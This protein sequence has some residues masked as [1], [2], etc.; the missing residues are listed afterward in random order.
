[1]LKRL[2][3]FIVPALALGAATAHAAPTISPA[4]RAA[5]R[6]DAKAQNN[7]SAYKNPRVRIGDVKELN[8]ST[9][10]VNA[11]LTAKMR[12]PIFAGPAKEHQMTVKTATFKVTFPG[13]KVQRQG[14]WNT[15]YYALNTNR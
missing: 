15:I 11:A 5:I 1:M 13:N 14:K 3:L 7:F 8:R 9:Y 2:A 4:A 10:Q 12:G 6:A